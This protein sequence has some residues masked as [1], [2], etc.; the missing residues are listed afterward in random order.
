MS[1]LLKN[2]ILEVEIGTP[3]EYYT[4]SRFDAS[5]NIKQITLNGQHSFCAS[6][7]PS[8]N[9]AY[10]FGLLNE[11]DIDLPC[12]FAGAKNGEYFHK[13]GVGALL[14]QNNSPYNF[15]RSYEIKRLNYNVIQ[16]SDAQLIFETKSEPIREMQYEYSKKITLNENELLIEYSLKNSGLSKIQ[17]KEYCHNFL[18]FNGQNIGKDYCL[19]LN[20]NIVPSQFNETVNTENLIQYNSN[21]LNWQASPERDFFISGLSNGNPLC[22]SWTLENSKEK[23]SVKEELDSVCAHF[24]LWGTK[25]VV[26]PELFVGIDLSPNKE[27]KWQRKYTFYSW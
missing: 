8:Y 10:G 25:H 22:K 14:K 26:S 19:S 3:S 18:A 16:E 11:F 15:F 24:N 12:N 9:S 7:K 2:N 6:E 4:G 21:K 20:E 27:K 23:L 5:G 13:I 1:H 17:A